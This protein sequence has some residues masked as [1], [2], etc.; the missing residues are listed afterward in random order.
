M[1]IRNYIEHE[2][3]SLFLKLLPQEPVD[4]IKSSMK[5]TFTVITSGCMSS[6]LNHQQDICNTIKNANR[7]I[8]L[9]IDTLHVLVKD[10]ID[11][12]C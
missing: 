2:V 10:I 9:G 7:D 8:G 11:S 1:N 12:P 3:L 4:T 5:L 6:P